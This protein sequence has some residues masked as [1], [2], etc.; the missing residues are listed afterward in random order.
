MCAVIY[1]FIP[2]SVYLRTKPETVHERIKKRCREEEQAI[3]LVSFSYQS[4][5]CDIAFRFW[6]GLFFLQKLVECMQCISVVHKIFHSNWTD[7][8]H[9]LSS[10]SL[11]DR[12]ALVVKHPSVIQFS[13]PY[14]YCTINQ[15]VSI[16]VHNRPQEGETLKCSPAAATFVPLWYL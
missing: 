5:S 15:I 7:F 12:W 10:S 16:V 14:Y 1:M 11:Q 13:K 4:T 3:P 8:F 2:I 6:R 9:M